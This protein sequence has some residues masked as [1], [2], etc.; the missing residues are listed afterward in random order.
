MTLDQLAL[1]GEIVGGIAIIFTLLYLAYETRRNTTMHISSATSDS[2]YRWAEIND[3]VAND[4]EMSEL[5][6]KIFDNRPLED[7]DATE[8]LRIT[9]SI[10]SV[11]QRL[12]AMHFQHQKG[13]IDDEHWQKYRV[14]FA[15]LF[16]L[17]GVAEWW[18]LEKNS[19]LF[20]D[21]FIREL[22][23]T[24]GFD[25]GATAQLVREGST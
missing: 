15:S 23:E 8:R 3:I 25:M 2:Y 1:I 17:K 7:F 22:E 10:R 4:K 13:L 14:F 6:V 9:F 16:K 18:L 12:A 5:W 19:S 11:I 24:E 21:S 20:T